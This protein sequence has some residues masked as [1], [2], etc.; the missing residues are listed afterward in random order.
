MTSVYH[1]RVRVDEGRKP[2]ASA[3]LFSLAQQVMRGERAG[4]AVQEVHCHL[5]GD[6]DYSAVVLVYP[7]TG[8]AS[9]E[10]NETGDAVAEDDIS[11]ADRIRSQDQRDA[12]EAERL[13]EVELNRQVANCAARRRAAGH[14][15]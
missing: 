10:A 9:S 5:T 13:R 12:E 14:D 15:D 1:L 8:L 2:T 7:A 11:A 3:L 6:G 4:E